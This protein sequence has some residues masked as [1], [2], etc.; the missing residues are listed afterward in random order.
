MRKDVLFTTKHIFKSVICL[1]ICAINT[2]FVDSVSYALEPQSQLVQQFVRSNGIDKGYIIQGYKD[3]K[4]TTE[5]LRKVYVT[6]ND[7]R[8][9]CPALYERAYNRCP[10]RLMRIR[11]IDSDKKTLAAAC[12][13]SLLF[14][15]S[16]FLE[17]RKSRLEIM[18][19][20][21]IHLIDSGYSLSL[22]QKWCELVCKRIL[23]FDRQWNKPLFS[24]STEQ[25]AAADSIAR[26][27]GLPNAYAAENPSETLAY[28]ATNVLY[29]GKPDYPVSTFLWSNVFSMPSSENPLRML[30]D[31]ADRQ[32]K[33]CRYDQAI[34]LLTKLL[35][36]DNK[37]VQAY[38][39]LGRV[40]CEKNDWEIAYWNFCHEVYLLQQL[41]VPGSTSVY[42]KA[43]T[44]K[45]KCAHHLVDRKFWS[46]YLGKNGLY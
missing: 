20:E 24:C 6:I 13:H 33:I 36:I 23:N 21:M 19:H 30:F 1:I 31:T 45:N 37:F 18:L 38:D 40:W 43:V 22:T 27:C 7:V 16:F 12:E 44:M 2:V 10:V 29:G 15:D 8:K 4:W 39:E 26:R 28:F 32:I 5:E 17:P 14:P 35:R 9:L 25:L 3:R 34:E 42:R 11:I 46:G 41:R